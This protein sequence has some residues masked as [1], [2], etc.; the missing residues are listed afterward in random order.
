M[1]KGRTI[2]QRGAGLVGKKGMVW[3]SKEDREGCVYGRGKGK[4][5]EREHF[6]MAVEM[7]VSYVGREGEEK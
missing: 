2:S 5:K 7:E 1:E 6:S 3:R 4:G